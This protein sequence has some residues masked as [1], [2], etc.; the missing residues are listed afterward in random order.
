MKRVYI[1]GPMS[2]MPAQ[3][4]A[5][6]ARLLTA[7]REINAA[8]FAGYCPAAD[9]LLGIGSERPFDVESYRAWSMA[10]LEVADVVYVVAAAHADGRYSEGVDAEVRRAV[11]MGIPVVFT[12]EDIR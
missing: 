1:A 12:V 5:N 4:L 7:W 3:Y 6:C 11:E 8:G 9:M 10:W 2:D